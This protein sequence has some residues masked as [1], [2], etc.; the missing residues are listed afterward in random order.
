MLIS[1]ALMGLGSGL[2]LAAL[3][4]L[5]VQAV[6]PHQTGAAGGMNTVMRTIGGAIG[7]QLSATFIAGHLAANG[8]PLVTGFTETFVMATAFLVVCTAAGFL[9]P[10][11]RR[12]RPAGLD[13]ALGAERG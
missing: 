1:A 9:I 13:P 5:I 7:G 11:R 8:E 6:E 4:N 3:G 12:E 2:A 10:G